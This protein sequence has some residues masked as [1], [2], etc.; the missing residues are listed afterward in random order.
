M[1][2]GFVTDALGYMTL[3]DMLDTCVQ[4]GI[5][6]LEFGCANWSRWPA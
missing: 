2:L 6:S 1:K 3:E 4:L 5:E